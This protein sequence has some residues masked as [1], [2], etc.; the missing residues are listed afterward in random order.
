MPRP[1]KIEIAADLTQP[2]TVPEDATVEELTAMIETAK[3]DALSLLDDPKAGRPA[4][5]IAKAEWLSKAVDVIT[6]RQDSIVANDKAEAEALAAVREKLAPKAKDA[7]ET[8]EEKAA[9]AKAVED[10]AK[11]KADADAATAV[12]AQGTVADAAAVAPGAPV[13]EGALVA[14]GS[15]RRSAVAAAASAGQATS[16]PVRRSPKTDAA[17]LT[18]SAGVAGIEGGSTIDFDELGKIAD[19]RFG[20]LPSGP[21][22]MRTVAPLGRI[23]VPTD[24]RLVASSAVGGGEFVDPTDAI[25]WAL[26]LDRLTE[27]YGHDVDSIVAAGGWCAPSETLYDLLNLT[28]R[29]G[30]LDVPGITVN[31]GGVRFSLGPDFAA[32]YNAGANFTRTEAQ[33]IAGTPQKPVVNIPCP[34]FTDNRM[35]VDGMYFTGDILSQKGYPEAYSD[36][37][38]KAATAFAHYVN[39]ASIADIEALSTVVDYTAGPTKGFQSIT[40]GLLGVLDIQITDM[41]YR[42][43]LSM[44]DAVEVIAPF[45]LKGALRSDLTK[46]LGYEGGPGVSDATLDSWFAIRNARIQWVYDWQDAFTGVSAGFGAATPILTWPTSAKVLIHPAG[47]FVRALNDVIDL[48]AVYDSTLLKTNQFVA[49]FLEQGRL[50]LKRAWD[51]RSVILPV[52]V[53]GATAL[54]IDYTLVANQPTV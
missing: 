10:E 13:A 14:S 1:R 16:L 25:N 4:E 36:F 38:T 22:G 32:V 26:S 48:Q 3:S 46:R 50:T 35:V 34:S 5:R 40:S 31:R 51:A 19:N 6:E 24:E 52:M 39:A 7:E 53:S 12:A 9:K 43:R 20:N 11:A 29:D 30:M 18:A 23:K 8:D 45:W 27:E 42:N 21:N 47:T 44:T 28:T 54:G 17:F 37:L 49:L 41:R 33:A 2:F 15:A